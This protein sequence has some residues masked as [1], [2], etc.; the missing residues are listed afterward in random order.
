LKKCLNIRAYVAGA[1]A[2]ITCPCHLPLTLP[3]LLTLTAG[4]AV[5]GWLANNTTTIYVAS[6]V[7]FIGGL[8]LAGKWLLADETEACLLDLREKRPAES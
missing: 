2:F 3:I 5:G 8:V 6:A 7:L 4:T 1:I